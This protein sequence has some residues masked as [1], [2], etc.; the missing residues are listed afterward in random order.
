[1][2]II[3]VRWTD[4]N[5]AWGY[6]QPHDITGKLGATIWLDRRMDSKTAAKVLG[7]EWSHIKFPWLTDKQCD[8][9]GNSIGDLFYRAGFRLKE[10]D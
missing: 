4:L 3:R 10:D 9:Y 2:P 6:A 8:H 7:H 1:M 5:T